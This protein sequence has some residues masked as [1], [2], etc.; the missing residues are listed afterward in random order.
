MSLVALTLL[1]AAAQD[2]PMVTFTQKETYLAFDYPKTWKHTSNRVGHVFEIPLPDT[3][4]K[5]TLLVLALRN[6]NKKDDWQLLQ[7]NAVKNDPKWELVRQWEGEIMGVPLLMTRIKIKEGENE[8]TRDSGMIYA[9]R[10]DKFVFHLTAPADVFS[11]AEYQWQEVLQTVRS[12]GGTGVKPFDPTKPIKTGPEVSFEAPKKGPPER[13]VLGEQSIAAKAAGT[14]YQLRY[15]RGWTVTPI[16]SGFS[17]KHPDVEGAVEVAVL[18]AVDSPPIYRALIQASAKSLELFSKVEKRHDEAI[19][20][21]RAGVLMSFISRTGAG[22]AGDIA[23]VDGAGG[24]SNEYWLL[25]WSGSKKNSGKA[26]D[27]LRDLMQILRV[28]A[29]N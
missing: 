29:A 8:L 12:T 15:P 2:K 26:M 13:P 6:S 4:K 18:S 21:T 22:M 28:E 11:V 14:D 16:G 10:F 27:R 3:E 24:L 7:A 17:F 20:Y 1:F 25:S 19:A 23:S 5:A 9:D